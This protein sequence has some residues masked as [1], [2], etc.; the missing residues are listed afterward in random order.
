M[1]FSAIS[2]RAAE[3]RSF[4]EMMDLAAIEKSFLLVNIFVMEAR[5]MSTA[6]ASAA[7]FV[8]CCCCFFFS[9]AISA[10]DVAV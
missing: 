8:G 4:R 9:T 5:R 7:T 1:R 6:S 2:T 3:R 10:V